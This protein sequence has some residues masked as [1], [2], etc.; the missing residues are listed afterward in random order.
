MTTLTSTTSSWIH[1][2]MT[3]WEGK[4]S[5][6]IEHRRV[7]RLLTGGSFNESSLFFLCGR[8]CEQTFS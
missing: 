5:A 1:G 2:S 3:F 4:A 6:V 7:H 8:A